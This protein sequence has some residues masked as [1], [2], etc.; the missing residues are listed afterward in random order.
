MKLAS[1]PRKRLAVNTRLSG[2]CVGT[3]KILGRNLKNPLQTDLAG[4]VYYQGTPHG[5]GPVT[6]LRSR[7]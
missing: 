4:I 6:I 7:Q 3:F 2:I 1:R 5:S